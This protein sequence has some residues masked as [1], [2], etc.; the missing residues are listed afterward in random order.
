MPSSV[1]HLPAVA[2][3]CCAA[4]FAPHVASAQADPGVP[5]AAAT[6]AA[7][8]PIECIEVELF[9]AS[10]DKVEGQTDRAAQIPEQNLRIIQD[11][12]IRHLPKE[13]RGTTAVAATAGGT[14][15]AG[16]PVASRTVVL[17]GNILDFRRGNMALRYFVGFGAGA[18]KVR[19]QLIVRAKEGGT[20][21]A[22][23]EIKDTK[24]GGVFGG[25]NTKGLDDFAEKAAEAAAAAIRQRPGQGV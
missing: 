14:G 11:S 12:I 10:A 4:I 20:V 1:R 24:W 2:V 18:Q 19:V 6:P 13:L 22:E 7:A 25:T 9:Q 23:R 8:G 5:A 21:L 16:C 17:A 15:G 3:I